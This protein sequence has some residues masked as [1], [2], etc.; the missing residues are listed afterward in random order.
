MWYAKAR[1]FWIDSWHRCSYSYSSYSSFFTI[2][3]AKFNWIENK[4]EIK[5]K[6]L[7]YQILIV[8]PGLIDLILPL[9]YL[10]MNYKLITAYFGQHLFEYNMNILFS[11]SLTEQTWN[12]FYYWCLPSFS[13][14]HKEC[15]VVDFEQIAANLPKMSS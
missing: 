9:T 4:E 14:V 5:W 12:L 7:F 10:F 1:W 13:F 2:A 3:N 11:Q 15:L 8:T 6:Q